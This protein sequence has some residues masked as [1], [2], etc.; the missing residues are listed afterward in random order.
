MKVLVVAPMPPSARAH[1]AI[2]RVLHAQVLGLRSRG[3]DVTVAVLAG[4]DPDHFHALEEAAADGMRIHAVVRHDPATAAERSRRRA[5]LAAGWLGTRKPWRS[6]WFHDSRLEGLARELAAAQS[7]DVVSLHDNAVGH[8][9]PGPGPPRVLTESEVRRP[10]PLRTSPADQDWRRWRRYQRDVWR[11]ADLIHVFSERDGQGVKSIAP[12]LASRVRVAPFGLDLA[13]LEPCGSDHATPRL[14]FVGDY[15][16][17]PNVDAALWL[18]REVMPRVVRT[19][20]DASLLLVGD[21]PPRELRL[22]E[23]ERV[24]VTG[25]VASA[26]SLMGRSTVVVAPVRIGGGM[27]VKVAQALA[28]GMPVVTT[29][30]GAEG[31]IGF[32]EPP[33][34]TA[35][36]AGAVADAAVRL[37]ADPDERRGLG[38]RARAFAGAHLSADAFAGRLEAIYEEALSR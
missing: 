34:V 16:H 23:S 38:A 18:G 5:R 15:T 11:R 31:L 4:P 17:A 32:G 12:D 27:R 33:L 7:F 30:R 14:V 9:D 28:L 37:L 19:M 29:A 1:A 10:R 8:V 21:D 35:E 3:H 36:E 13:S 24:H 26:D 22:L 20:P 25:A 6:V 2:P